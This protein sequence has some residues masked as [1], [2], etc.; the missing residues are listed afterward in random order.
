MH[1]YI[2]KSYAALFMT[3]PLE[4]DYCKMWIKM[5]QNAFENDI[6]KNIS[7]ICSCFIVTSLRCE[8][9]LQY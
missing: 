6:Y 5:K 1:K 7:H 8:D 9:Y 4:P 2:I 3:N